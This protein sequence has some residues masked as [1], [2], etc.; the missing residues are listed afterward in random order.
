MTTPAEHIA[1]AIGA[2]CDVEYALPY[3]PPSMAAKMAFVAPS[4]T[5]KEI[6]ERLD[7]H[8]IGLDAFILASTV[9]MLTSQAWL[10]AQTTILIDA[11][12]IDVGTDEVVVSS[13]DA[14]VIFSSTDGSTFLGC[15][16]SYTRHST[17]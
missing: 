8:T 2:A 7:G 15:R 16:I 6:G 11:A 10:D 3:R 12:P 5:W 9:D 4:E 13:I 14:P 1:N 17:V